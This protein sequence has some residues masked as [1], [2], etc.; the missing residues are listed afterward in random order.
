M[1]SSSSPP[2]PAVPSKVKRAQLNDLALRLFAATNGA[3]DANHCISPLSISLVLSVLRDSANPVAEKELT[4]LLQN[5]DARHMDEI[6]FKVER[7]SRDEAVCIVANSIWRNQEQKGDFFDYLQSAYRCEVSAPLTL[8][9]ITEWIKEKTKGFI[10]S[11]SIPEDTFT[12]DGA[13]II[14]T[15]YFD[16]RW[17]H[18]DFTPFR[19]PFT[20]PNG[21]QLNDH[22]FLTTTERLDYVETKSGWQCVDV[23]LKSG[24]GVKFM[25]GCDQSLVPTASDVEESLINPTKRL[26]NLQIPI[27]KMESPTISLKNSLRALGVN[28][29][30][31]KPPS[32]KDFKFPKIDQGFIADAFHKVVIDVS[33]EGVKAAGATVFMMARYGCAMQVEQPLKVRFDR[34]FY[35]YI[36]HGDILLFMG[37]LTNP[38]K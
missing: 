11:I 25:L 14:N 28:E 8:E 1:A 32:P 16:S 29:A 13:C 20:L 22:T 21:K 26:I 9:A 5:V 7:S 33:R 35:F 37:H 27:F 2:S 12:E 34:P 6:L 15:I 10:T 24:F 3:P 17:A 31:E 23:P 38:A 19:Q 4:A 36:H 30:F 18:S